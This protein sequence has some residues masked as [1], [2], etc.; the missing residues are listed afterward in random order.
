MPNTYYN[1]FVIG[2]TV[3]TGYTAQFNV[4]E[5]NAV[6]GYVYDAA[7]SQP[8]KD[9]YVFAWNWVGSS[10][11]LD[12]AASGLYTFT[13]ANGY[14][15]IVPYNYT[16]P[17]VSSA[18]RIVHLKL[19]AV[20]AERF[21]AG[22]NPDWQN[23]Q[24]SQSNLGNINLDRSSFQG[25]VSISNI[26]VSSGIQ[27][28]RAGNTLT[29]SGVTIQ[30]GASSDFTARIEINADA[31]FHAENGSETHIYTS[32]TFP[33][34]NDYSDPNFTI[35]NPDNSG[36][37]NNESIP[38]EIEISFI[39]KNGSVYLDLKPNPNNGIFTI[40]L[41]AWEEENSAMEIRVFG[42]AGNIVYSGD[43]ERSVAQ[44]DLSKLPKG[45]YI[46]QVKSSK[47]VVNQK[48]IIN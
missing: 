3:P 30:S 17:T 38:E 2:A 12:Y 47:Y 10:I 1:P 22:S 48:I 14:F 7:T 40:E 43:T 6:T 28:F 16:Q 23:F 15:K 19:S 33:D 41:I 11:P 21:E 46:I 26:T 44:M 18:Q 32:Q 13:D 42:L 25:D 5:T 31:E 34:C 9:A 4:T 39:P 45:I 20:G 37:S 29:A 27:N 35:A 8:V 24:L 36:N